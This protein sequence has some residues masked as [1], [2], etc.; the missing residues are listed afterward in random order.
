MQGSSED[1]GVIPRVVK[2]SNIRNIFRTVETHSEFCS[3]Q[4]IFEKKQALPDSAL[5][6]S[7]SYCEVL[8]EEI[9]DLL[10]PRTEASPAFSIS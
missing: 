6:V 2:V 10:G 5:K 9:Y 7:F 1:P 3:H 8:M 4:S